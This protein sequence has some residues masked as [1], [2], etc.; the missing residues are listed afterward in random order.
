[1]K[2]TTKIV[3]Y[4]V[5]AVLIILLF[6]ELFDRLFQPPNISFE[7]RYEFNVRYQ[8]SGFVRFL[9]VP[10]QVI[11][12]VKNRIINY[13]KIQYKINQYGFRGDDFPIKK[14]KGEVRIV[15]LGGSHVFDLNCFDFEG[16]YG[17]PHM[18][19]IIFQD[20]GCNVRVINAGIPGHDTMSL[21]NKIILDTHRYEPDVIII[22]SIWN[23]T[24]WISRT[25]DATPF[26]TIGPKAF[27]KNPM[28][29]KINF[30]DKALGFSI[31]YRKARDN[32][33]E[34]ELTR[35]R[36]KR[37]NEGIINNILTT[38]NLNRGLEQYKLNL[39]AAVQA[40]K[41]I[42]ALP[43]LAIEERFVS[44]NNNDIDKKLIEYEIVN[45]NNHTELVNLF[46]SCDAII[47]SISIEN[48][49]PLIDVNKEME[50]N[51]KYF[52]DHIHTTPEGSRYIAKSYYNF[53]KPLVDKACIQGSIAGE[54]IK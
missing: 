22:N 53:L 47:K 29:E 7:E 40:I 15:I 35:G 5:F 54:F 41:C 24:K 21:F 46:Q 3:F 12:N 30:L 2:R 9:P 44:H 33:W 49:I 14:P 28:L 42:K 20:N 19:Q 48:A 6:F 36:K 4:N 26:L 8:P 43:V 13:D 10:G 27:R 1:M 18:L 32:Y 50:G 25:A 38:S 23:D 52:M 17:F 37:T 45:V 34:K 16:N 11:Y 39:I 31:L 51:P